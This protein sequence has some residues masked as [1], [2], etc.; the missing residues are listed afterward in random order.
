VDIAVCCSLGSSRIPLA[1]ICGFSG[2]RFFVKQG[3]LNLA[4]VN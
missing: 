1:D 3:E 2:A 4:A